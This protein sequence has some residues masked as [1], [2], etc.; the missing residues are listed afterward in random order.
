MLGMNDYLTS[1]GH[2]EFLKNNGAVG[3]NNLK[4]GNLL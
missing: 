1:G 2:F 3:V 4:V